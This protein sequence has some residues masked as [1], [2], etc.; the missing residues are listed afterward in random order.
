MSGS[1]ITGGLFPMYLSPVQFG[2]KLSWYNKIPGSR[3]NVIPLKL[4][5]G[6]MSFLPRQGVLELCHLY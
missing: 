1:L 2:K 3:E 4:N 5:S 6:H